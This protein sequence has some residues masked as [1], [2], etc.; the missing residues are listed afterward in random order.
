MADETQYR[1]ACRFFNV[2]LSMILLF[3]ISMIKIPAIGTS[4]PRRMAKIKFCLVFGF[5]IDVLNG[6][7]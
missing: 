4:N 6:P 1:S 3:K 2:L 5:I 7:A